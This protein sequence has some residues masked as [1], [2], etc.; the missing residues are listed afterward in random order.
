VCGRVGGSVKSDGRAKA[1]PWLYDFIHHCSF[2]VIPMGNATVASAHFIPFGH[3]K[4]Q[5]VKF[6]IDFH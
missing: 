1:L 6:Q 3:E 4:V 2:I 5:I